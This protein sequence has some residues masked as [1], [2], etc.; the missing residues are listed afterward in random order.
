[1]SKQ[2][3]LPDLFAIAD[4]CRYQVREVNGADFLQLASE[5]EVSGGRVEAVKRGKKN[6]DWVIGFRI[7]V[8][9]IAPPSP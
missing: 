7:G 1:M 4:P 6:G 8:A 3:E 5:V 2:N 9:P